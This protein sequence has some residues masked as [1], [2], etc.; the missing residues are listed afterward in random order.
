MV[1]CIKCHITNKDRSCEQREPRPNPIVEQARAFISESA[2]SSSLGIFPRRGWERDI[3]WYLS[4]VIQISDF[5]LI[6]FKIACHLRLSGNKSVS[7]FV[8]IPKSFKFGCNLKPFSI[9]KMHTGVYH[10]HLL[11]TSIYIN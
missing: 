6:F 5:L 7:Y 11:N 3:L 10:P 8:T 4:N 2:S 9:A 1:S